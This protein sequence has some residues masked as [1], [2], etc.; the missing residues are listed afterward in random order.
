M[1]LDDL[2]KERIRPEENDMTRDSLC[3]EARSIIEKRKRDFLER[4]TDEERIQLESTFDEENR[5]SAME[6]KTSYIQ[7][8][9]L[10]AKLVSELLKNK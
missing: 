4:V 8:M 9:R 5:V 7:G 1:I 10:G 6:L 2:Y 3:V